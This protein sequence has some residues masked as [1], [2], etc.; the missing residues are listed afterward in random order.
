MRWEQNGY[1]NRSLVLCVFSFQISFASRGDF[2][3]AEVPYVRQQAGTAV[4]QLLRQCALAQQSPANLSCR[5]TLD[6]KRE[7]EDKSCCCSLPRPFGMVLYPLGVFEPTFSQWDPKAWEFSDQPLLVLV[8]NMQGC[9]KAS[10]EIG[11]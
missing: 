8:P 11:W 1:D 5:L 9:G 7:R 4:S 10:P 6:W 3:S 2:Q